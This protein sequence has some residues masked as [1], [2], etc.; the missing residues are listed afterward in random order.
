MKYLYAT[1]KKGFRKP[2]CEYF[3]SGKEFDHAHRF[4]DKDLKLIN[5]LNIGETATLY[6]PYFPA[7][8][9]KITLVEG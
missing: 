6:D 9:I 1:G 4:T 5:N 7:D 8:V 2:Q 3:T